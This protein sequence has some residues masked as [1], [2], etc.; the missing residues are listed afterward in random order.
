MC[1]ITHT[2]NE[3]MIPDGVRGATLLHH[4]AETKHGDPKREHINGVLAHLTNCLPESTW[5]CGRCLVCKRDKVDGTPII[6]SKCMIEAARLPGIE[7]PPSM[8]KSVAVK[9]SDKHCLLLQNLYAFG[10]ARPGLVRQ[11]GDVVFVWHGEDEAVGGEWFRGTAVA[12]QPSAVAHFMHFE[13]VL[14]CGRAEPVSQY[15][16][17]VQT[18]RADEHLREEMDPNK[19]TS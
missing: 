2:L 7:R 16:D 9:R 15:N 5:R 18:W 10:S 4:L 1:R 11:C 12:Y 19:Q 3:H 17:W 8:S 6:V 13:R 14:P